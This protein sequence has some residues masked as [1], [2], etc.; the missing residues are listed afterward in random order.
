MQDQAQI[1]IYK[2]Y[3]AEYKKNQLILWTG[4]G[5]Y[6]VGAALTS[7]YST[8][9]IK[10]IQ[11]FQAI[12]LLSFAYATVNLVQFKASNDFLK[13]A[14]F[15]YF[16]WSLFVVF[17]GYEYTYESTK[18]EFFRSIFKHFLGIIVFIPKN[19][20]FYKD[21]S[22]I[23]T[24]LGVVFILMNLLYYDIIFTH[25][26]QNVNQ[27]F[28]FEGF[29]QNLGITA[30]FVLLTF[31]YHSKYKNIIAFV[32]LTFIIAVATYKARRGIMALSMVYML[33]FM[34]IFYIYTNHKVLIALMV[35]IFTVLTAINWDKIYLQNR[36]SFFEQITTRGTEDTRSGVE[37]AFKRDFNTVDWVI[38]RGIN[39][40]YWCPNI[41]MGNTTGYRWMIETDYLNIILKGGIIQLGLIV[42]IGL[43]AAFKAMFFSR[44]LLSK[45]AGIWI[46]LWIL[47]LYPL[48]VYNM[49]LNYILFWVCVSIG[50]SRD[51]RM[52]PD[53]KIMKEYSLKL[54]D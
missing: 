48:N 47:S 20:K 7:T 2:E 44:N 13:I 28:T 42:I 15:F 32:V 19:I 51:L 1:T 45:V 9:M 25:Y 38:G 52:L 6:A 33:I 40:E 50:F 30:P 18:R 23:I 46:V 8:G 41:D 37:R 34:V 27:K 49:D 14:M 36:A 3:L 54:K 17:H 39:G 31:I 5:L 16:S 26:D 24:I 11:L 43:V 22:N 35:L 12:G 53:E 4:I 21:I 29:T 10:V